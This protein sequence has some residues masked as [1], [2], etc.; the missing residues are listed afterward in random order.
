MQT[1][2]DTLKPLILPGP[3]EAE[4]L[5]LMHMLRNKS[6]HLGPAILRQMG[7]HDRTG[8]FYVFLPRKWPFIWERDFKAHDTIASSDRARGPSFFTDLLINQDIVSFAGCLHRKV[9]GVLRA[10]LSEIL[11]MYRA[12]ETFSTNQAAIMELDR[13]SVVFKFEN[14]L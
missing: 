11:R 3:P 12:F 13:N 10:G 8:K 1:L 2:Y 6:I 9:I 7:L 14:F 5:S 4:W